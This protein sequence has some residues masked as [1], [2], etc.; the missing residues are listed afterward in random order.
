MS[1]KQREPIAIC[2]GTQVPEAGKHSFSILHQGK[3]KQA[4]LIRFKGLVYAYINQCVHMPKALDCEDV[5]IFDETGQYIQCSMHKICYDPVNGA[6]VSELCSGK[7]LTAL[8]VKEQGEW[9]Y[10][11]DKKAISGVDHLL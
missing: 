2:R 3:P 9:V 8:K 10:W 11:L 4:V 6:S 7:K 1:A 5:N